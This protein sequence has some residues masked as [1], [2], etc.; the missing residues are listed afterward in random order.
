MA[1]LIPSPLYHPDQ[2][3]DACGV[4]LIARMT[5]E[6]SHDVINRAVAALKALAHRGAI[7]A[8]AVTGD[9]AGLLTQIPV[10]LLRE[11]LEQRGKNLFHDNDLGVGMVFLPREDEYAQ[12]HCKKIVR[13]A[14]EAEGLLWLCWRDVPTNDSCL[15]RKALDTQPLIAQ[16]LVART[17]EIEE[18]EFE[19]RLFLAQKTIE[20]RVVEEKIE[21][22]DF[23]PMADKTDGFYICSFS[24]RTIVYKGMLTPQQLRKYFTDLKSPKFTSAFAIFHQRYSTNTFPMWHLAHP[25]RMVA[26][27]GEI[28]TIRGNRN[29]MR[30]RE[31]S[32]YHGVWGDRYSDLKPLVQPNGSD[33]AT[34]DNALQLIT[35]GGRNPLHA[36][37]MM[38]PPAWEHDDDLSDEAKAFFRYHATMM[39]P[40]DGPAAVAFTDG[41]IIGATLDRNGL[42][43]ARYKIYDDGYV[44][45]ASEAG[46]VFDFPGKVVEAGRL[47]PGRMIAVDLTQQR[48]LHDD[49]IKAEFTSTPRFLEW[50]KDHLVNIEDAAGAAPSEESAT[51]ATLAQQIAFGYESDERELVLQPLAE[52]KEPTGSMGE[53]TPLAVLSRRPRLL[54]N[55]FKQLFA[56]VTNPPIDSIR[57]KAVMSLSMFLG[58]RLGL[59]EEL[60][61]TAGLVELKSPILFDH[62]VA[63]LDGIDFLKDRV[64]RLSVLFDASA[65][66][67]GL[68]PAVKALTAAAEKAYKEKR[69]KIIILSDKGVSADQAAIPMLLAV[70]AVH[71]RLIRIGGR[72]RCDLV[73]ETGEAREV[74]QIACLLGMGVNAVNPYLAFDIVSQFATAGEAGEGTTPAQARLNYETAICAGLRKIMAKMGIST[75][76]SYRGAQMFEAL[77]VSHKLIEE[78]FFGVPSPIGGID[79]LQVAEA[80]LVRHAN[81]FPQLDAADPDN[82]GE[83]TAL[84]LKPEGYYRVNKRGE[85]EYHA[86][87]PKLI[88]SMNKFNRK[89]DFEA[90]QPWKEQAD[91]HQPV[92]LKDLLKI[93]F[94]EEGIELDEVEGIEDIRKRFT[95]AGM[96]MGALSPEAHEALAIAMN[97]IGGKSNSGEGGEDPERYS[98]RENGDNAS[99]A[100]K[101]VASGRFGVTAEYLA[102]A[103]EIEIKMAQG[104][105]PGEGGQLP[106]HKVS[107]MI[108][109]LRFSIPGVT[110]ISPPPHH[111][112]YSIEDLAQLI[113]DLKE[114]NPRAKVCVKLV[115]SSGVGTV[116]AGVAKAYADVVLVS[117]HD[118]GTGASPL[119]SIKN[120]GS[121]WEIGV[122]EAH[123]VLMMNGLRGRVT[124][125]TDGGMK[126]G[127]DI[128][129]AALLGAEEFNFGTAALIAAGCAMFRVCHLNTCPVGVATQREDLRAKFRGKPENVIN[130]FNAVAEDVRLYLAKLGAKSINDIIGRVELLEQIDDPVNPKTKLINLGGL[131]HNPDPSGEAER[132]HTRARN[133]R[134]GGEGSLDEAILQEARDVILGKSA[135]LVARYK[136][137]NVNRDIGTHLSGQIAYQKGNAGLPPGTIDLT[138][139]G[140]A[141][142]SFG[143]FLVNG[144]RITL[145]GEANDYVGKGMNGGE[146]IIR[147]R[148][149]SSFA[150]HEQSIAGNTCLYGATGGHLFAAGRAGER[151]GVRN[152]GATAVVEGVGDHGCEYMTGGL[153]V[154]LG[155]TGKNF[156]AGMSGGLGFIYD[157]AGDFDQKINPAM[158]EAERLSDE[159]EIASLAQ[160][161]SVH[162]TLT[163]SPHAQALLKDWDNTVKKFWKAVPFPPNAE[164]PKT[165]YRFD[166]AKAPALV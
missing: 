139:T 30:A 97:R 145:N 92:A 163:G 158:I 8:D 104:A 10:E 130:F 143:T 129:I 31:R 164:T 78:C 33:S 75:L 109:T 1:K 111:D 26:H 165:L 77:G 132:Y 133:E 76:F 140:S 99:S 28:N 136:V 93:R 4:G 2:E 138:F 63:A 5:G 102:N 34:F 114:V 128:V 161:V 119:A 166:E 122:A 62:Q 81:A 88:A 134:F 68:E 24:S 27:N 44:I 42:R 82:V 95:T 116:A 121:A 159:E 25:F 144:L 38:M 150:W 65:G 36:A 160:L 107:K 105:K 23:N 55:Y 84:A 72:V 156:G 50:C 45:L 11:H 69:A 9:G 14:V 101:Q 17:E 90:F 60:P 89:G 58:G 3:H 142:Q 32:P 13:E 83:D 43:P 7:D 117:G 115:S 52:G 113:F 66:P 40:W 21:G 118:G 112:I 15:G 86:W 49:E 67:E 12:A 154:V 85:G 96:S 37:M 54:Y 18:D 39:E 20:R 56:Q 87:S 146:I 61:K 147:P 46:L 16:A 137:T 151:F 103:K 71:Q 57:E 127:R 141:G 100:I 6:R 35:L 41:K 135:R 149:T 91:D 94:P 74:H 59:F 53:D 19:R 126:T 80:T 153:I 22:V 123:Q 157:E 124:L 131:L 51:T 108:A 110:L 64:V 73:A 70:G 152:S 47:G 29:L 98:V 148:E 155:P 162:A 106:G 125:R 120:A 79:Y 48:F